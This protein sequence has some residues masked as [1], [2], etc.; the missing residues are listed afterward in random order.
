MSLQAAAFAALLQSQSN[1]EGDSIVLMEPLV[2]STSP[3]STSSAN[4]AA[5]EVRPCQWDKEE[6]SLHLGSTEIHTSPNDI[7]GTSHVEPMDED[8]AWGPKTAA[9]PEPEFLPSTKIKELLNFGP[10]APDN[11]KERFHELA[12][13]HI[14]AFGFDG[15]L[16][17]NANKAHIQTKEDAIPITVPMYQASPAKREV[18]DKQLDVWFEQKV[19]EPSISPWA[20]PIVI[21]YRN[22]KARFCVDYQKLNEVTIVDEH[23]IPR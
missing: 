3:F 17:Q 22:G 15:R 7:E 8:N 5:G 18:I 21:V 2:N 23:P 4:V 12:S 6:D 19:I 13:K 1:S 14:E 9:L 10:E 11:I 20:A 16:G